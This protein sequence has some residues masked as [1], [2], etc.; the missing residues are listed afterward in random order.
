MSD[1]GAGGTIDYSNLPNFTVRGNSNA[2]DIRR[3]VAPV[4]TQ[5]G[6]KQFAI[7]GSSGAGDAF[8]KTFT[9]LNS[10]VLF[11]VVDSPAAGFCFIGITAPNL[12]TADCLLLELG[13]EIF[14][15]AKDLNDITIFGHAGASGLTLSMIGE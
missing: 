5:I 1:I 10:G 8:G 15:P 11:R 7:A 13:D 3:T 2:T 9:T 12:T 14:M 4:P 6:T